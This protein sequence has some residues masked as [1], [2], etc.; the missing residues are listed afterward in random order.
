[1][2]VGYVLCDLVGIFVLCC[3]CYMLIFSLHF[4]H[5]VVLL[6][7]LFHVIIGAWC[8]LLL[9]LFS[10]CFSWTFVLLV[11]SLFVSYFYALLFFSRYS[12]CCRFHIAPLTL[13]RSPYSFCIIPLVLLLTLPLFLCYSLCTIV[14]FSLLLDSCITISL[15]LLFSPYHSSHDVTPLTLFLHCHSSCVSSTC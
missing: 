8:R 3:H 10:C 5:V 4:F 11:M 2:H 1:M 13:F 7:L 15:T 9:L 14:P 12:S 6:A